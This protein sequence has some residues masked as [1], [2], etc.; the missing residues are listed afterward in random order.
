MSHEEL[1]VF[2][3]YDNSNWFLKGKAAWNRWYW[4]TNRE[5]VRI[6]AKRLKTLLPSLGKA[7][8][9]KS[10][11][12][13]RYHL[14]FPDARL[15]KEQELNVMLSSLSHKGH[16]WFSIA[17]RDTALRVSGKS[18]GKVGVPYLVEIVE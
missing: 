15:T 10:N 8:I 13:G 9:M 16:V 18:K 4:E 14:R 2:L 7:L 5:L 3:D 12:K 6:E 11:D 17:V 1:R